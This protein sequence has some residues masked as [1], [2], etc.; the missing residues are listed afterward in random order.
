MY[1]YNFYC[2]EDFTDC[3]S[4]LYF[5]STNHNKYLEIQSVLSKYGIIVEF[6]K[7]LLVEIQSDSIEEIAIAKS[8]DAFAEISK[9]VI[10]EDDGLFIPELNDFPGQY[11]SYAYKTIGN[12]GILKLLSNSKHRSACF[13]SFFAFYDGTYSQSFAGEIEGK[14]SDKIT[15]GGWGYDP[16]FIPVGFDIT[17]GQLQIQNR[18]IEVSHRAKALEKFA[19][20]YNTK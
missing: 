9:P 4:S 7:V 12:N 3:V 10:V 8:K 18:K 17:F 16:I 1:Y 5:V 6:Y 19:Q 2:S 13:K 20:W 15:E 14:I 11:S